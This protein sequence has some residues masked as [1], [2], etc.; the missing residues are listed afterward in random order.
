MLNTILMQKLLF[1]SILFY[2]TNSASA[3]VWNVGS[4]KTYKKPSEVASLVNNGDTVYIDPELYLDDACKWNKS[5]LKLI[6]IV[7]DDSRPIIRY[8]GYIPNGKGIWVFESPGISDDIYIANI[9]FEGA[10]V[11]DNQGGN[12]A[13]IRFQANNLTIRNCV[14]RNCQNGILEGHGAVKSSNVSVLACEFDNNGYSGYEHHIYINAST[15]TLL[16]E[17][18]Y[19]HDPRGEANSVKTRAQNAFILYN[20]IDEA[21]GNGSY[22]INIAQGGN[23]IIMGN[24]IIQGKAG[25]NHAIVGYDDDINP[26][27]DF[28][29]VNNTVIN[30]F[31]GNVRYF[32][33][34]PIG[35]DRFKIF[36]NIF[37]SVPNA[38]VTFISG[39]VPP[40]MDTAGNIFSKNFPDPWFKDVDGADFSLN[41]MAADIVNT[42]IDAG[43]DQYGFALIPT[44]SFVSLAEGLSIRTIQGGK[45][46]PGAYEYTPKSHTYS[47]FKTVNAFPNPTNSFFTIPVN[48]LTFRSIKIY[49]YLGNSFSNYTIRE[50]KDAVVIELFSAKSG[51]YFVNID[52]GNT[53]VMAKVLILN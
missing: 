4:D 25:A 9:V 30:Y 11:T 1:I 52:C 28:Y 41:E 36:N 50:D 51:L 2:L 31:P 44:M 39:N 47:S 26:I 33:I 10:R 19:F 27:E 21:D 14:F 17:G 53:T 37:S 6:G 43:F 23:N 22:E 48:S 13:G 7:T 38:S 5:G 3:A 8:T 29:F 40:A 35:I 32:H 46:D 42:G 45:I 34:S 18:C 16:I 20:Y 15:D 12:G 49:D 24:V